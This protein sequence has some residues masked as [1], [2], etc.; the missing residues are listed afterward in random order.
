LVAHRVVVVVV[1][2]SMRLEMTRFAASLPPPSVHPPDRVGRRSSSSTATRAADMRASDDADER[3]DEALYGDERTGATHAVRLTLARRRRAR[4]DDGYGKDDA[5]EARVVDGDGDGELRRLM[6]GLRATRWT[7]SR[8]MR[9]VETHARDAKTVDATVRWRCRACSSEEARLARRL[10]ES[11]EGMGLGVVVEECAT[12]VTAPG[13][14]PLGGWSDAAEMGRDLRLTEDVKASSSRFGDFGAATC[15]TAVRAERVGVI[16]ESVREFIRDVEDRF[17]TAH[18]HVAYGSDAFAF[19]EIGSRGC[20]RFDALVDLSSDRWS[21][22]RTL[23]HTD[24]PWLP[25]INGLLSGGWNVNVSVVYSRP[26]AKVQ[27]WHADGRHLDVECS[28]ATGEGQ[29]M[30]YGVCVFMPLIDLD[31]TTGFTQFFLKSHKTS[32]LIGF[33]EAASMLNCAFDGILKA[34]QSVLYDYRLLHRGMANASSADR[35][36]LQFLYTV[37][38]YRETKN[39]GSESIW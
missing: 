5:N 13:Y 2:A 35:P 23:A 34:G 3:D 29:A 30:P 26:G 1:G 9:I 39:Y 32:Q 25:Y 36:V 11:V 4:D 10:T 22:L 28:P 7:T 17:A 8:E 27:E 38:A 6:D 31:Q 14:V 33:G 19:K 20:E 37:P 24:A 12:L 16:R 15:E 21:H 18:K